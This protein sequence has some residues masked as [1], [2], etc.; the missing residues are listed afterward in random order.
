MCGELPFR[1]LNRF[2]HRRQDAYTKEGL[3]TK[4]IIEPVLRAVLVDAV[5]KHS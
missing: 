1:A 3:P 2:L 5:F 4:R